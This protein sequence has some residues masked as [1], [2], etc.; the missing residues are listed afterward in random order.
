MTYRLSIYNVA[1][2]MRS[3]LDDPAKCRRVIGIAQGSPAPDHVELA[4]RHRDSRPPDLDVPRRR[5]GGPRTGRGRQSARAG[6]HASHHGDWRCRRARL[7]RVFDH[8]ARMREDLA[9][10]V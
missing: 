4:L 3:E 8:G 5:M 10:T 6:G 9:G 1:P 7:E 2:A